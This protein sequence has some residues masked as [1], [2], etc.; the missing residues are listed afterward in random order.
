MLRIY[1]TELEVLAELR[2]VIE[3]IE[4]RDGDLGRQMR[5]TCI[6]PVLDG[7]CIVTEALSRGRPVSA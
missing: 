3:R 6:D 4:R 1:G 7:E 5:M 2:P